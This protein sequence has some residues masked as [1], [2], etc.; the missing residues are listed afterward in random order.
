ML[1]ISVFQSPAQWLRLAW[2]S[3][4]SCLCPSNAE[5]QGSPPHPEKQEFFSDSSAQLPAI[6][7]KK[8]KKK[9]PSKGS[10]HVHS[11]RKGPWGCNLAG[12]HAPEDVCEDNVE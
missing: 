5:L 10:E 6:E 11:K 12:E 7:L 9:D 8:K 2:K 4:S 3:R 1:H